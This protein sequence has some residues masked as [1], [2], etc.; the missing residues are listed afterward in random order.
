M[1]HGCRLATLQAELAASDCAASPQPSPARPA[2]QAQESEKQAAAASTPSNA[3]DAAHEHAP[4][5]GIT[6]ATAHAEQA[7][8]AEHRGTVTEATAADPTTVHADAG[9]RASEPAQPSASERSAGSAWDAHT[10]AWTSQPGAASRWS[11]S[12]VSERSP[13][14]AERDDT[15]V[16]RHAQVAQQSTDAPPSADGSHK[17]SEQGVLPLD[18]T[19]HDADAGAGH[20]E[21]GDMQ[22]IGSAVTAVAQQ[23]AT[24]V[25]SSATELTQAAHSSLTDAYHEV[26]SGLEGLHDASATPPDAGE[27]AEHEGHASGA[28]ESSTAGHSHRDSA[29]PVAATVSAE[30][31]VAAQG[32]LSAGAGT[33]DAGH[34]QANATPAN[35][36]SHAGSLPSDSPRGYAEAPGDLGAGAKPVEPGMEALQEAPVPLP[37]APPH[38]G[39]STD[40]E[41]SGAD[42]VAF[43][44][45]TASADADATG[46]DRP[47]HVADMPAPAPVGTPDAADAPVQR[48]GGDKA[49]S[50]GAAGSGNGNGNGNAGGADDEALDDEDFEDVAISASGEEDFDDEDD[51]LDA[52]WGERI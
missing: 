7:N 3:T 2:N 10:D 25:A 41:R 50:D 44:D 18:A 48:L 37:V 31:A 22:Q 45:S 17:Q 21:W 8:S 32:S 6:S 11:R 27:P 40:S 15:P 13:L 9:A 33:A 29:L 46:A 14:A 24:A 39:S 19:S 35:G 38:T 1:R 20:D 52:D 4:N 43:K 42:S 34:C 23:M 28:S 26:S 49:S 5:A 12:P 47:G 30:E 51:D 36:A 16:D